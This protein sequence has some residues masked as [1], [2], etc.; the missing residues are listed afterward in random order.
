MNFL[1]VMFLR[2]IN[3]VREPQIP[4]MMNKSYITISKRVF[5][6]N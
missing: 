4:E 2:Q 1:T 6:D 3:A 5:K